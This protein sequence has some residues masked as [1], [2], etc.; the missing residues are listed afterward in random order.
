MCLSSCYFFSDNKKASHVIVLLVLVCIY[1]L[2]NLQLFYMRSILFFLS[3]F[4]LTCIS[5]AKVVLPAYF[6]DNMVLQQN[7]KVTF[8]GKA[9]LGKTLKV[10]TGW[11]NEVYVTPVN[12]DGYW[13]LSVPTPAAGGPYTLTFT[14]GK[15]LQLKNVMVG[16]V[17]FCSGQSNMEMPVAGWGKVMNYEQEIAEANYPSIRLFHK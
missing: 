3:F 5:Y 16:E 6:T 10:T 8:H 12:K 4:S 13:T 14:D 15:K 2:V 17:W 7:T 1:F 9:A 11:N